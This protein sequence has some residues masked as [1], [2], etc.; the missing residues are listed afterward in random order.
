MDV[1]F[2]DFAKVL[3]SAL[4]KGQSDHQLTINELVD[5]LK[6]QLEPL[7]NKKEIG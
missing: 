4:D 7:V 5:D 3:E 6:C 2:N 1:N